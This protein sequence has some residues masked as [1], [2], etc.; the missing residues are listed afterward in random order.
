MANNELKFQFIKSPDCRDF[1]V[2][3]AFGGIAPSGKI[4]AAFYSERPVIPAVTVQP[5]TPTGLGPEIIEKREQREGLVRSVHGVA[6]F[7]MQ[8]AIAFRDW[9]NAKIDELGKIQRSVG[10]GSPN[11]GRDK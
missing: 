8:S 5:V 6:Y 11:A 4:V 1:P 7:D 3:G 9:L 2:D 10:G